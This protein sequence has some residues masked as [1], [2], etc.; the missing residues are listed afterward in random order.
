MRII[1]ATALIRL[2]SLI[3]LRLLHGLAVPMGWIFRIVPWRRHSVIAVNLALCFP[4]LDRR[5]RE[6]LHRRHLIEMMRLVLE[7]GA[8]WYWSGK[9]LDRHIK[10]IDGWEQ[11]ESVCRGDRGV[12]FVGAHFGNWEILPLWVSRKVDLA[13]LYRAPRAPA[14]DRRITASRSRFGARLIASGSPAMRK[15]LATLREGGAIGMLADQQPKQGDGVFVPFFGVPA[16]TMTLV[17]RLARRTGCAI[18]FT[19]AQ[20]QPGGWA[21][22]FEQADEAIADDDPAKGMHTMN[23]WLESE[24]LAE[25]AQ[26]LWN[27]KRFSLRPDGE[28]PPYPARK[29][30]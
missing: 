29:R 15:M 25:P 18:F 6:R 19:S 3:P 1:L 12:I 13:A 2:L 17:N 22:R 26:Y 9:R 10:S 5:E 21:L 7:S 8:V 4:D 14:I 24:V 28:P 11:V 20:R 27:Y 30:R 23:R 16:L